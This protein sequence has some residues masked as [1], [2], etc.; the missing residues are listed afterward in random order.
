MVVGIDA[1]ANSFLAKLAQWHSIPTDSML[2]AYISI[3]QGGLGL[4]D[5]SSRAFPNFV[6]TMCQ[7]IRYGEWRASP[8]M[9]RTPLQAPLLPC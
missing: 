4:M 3:T 8:S 2:I 6:L 5:A 9:P 7:A 1:M